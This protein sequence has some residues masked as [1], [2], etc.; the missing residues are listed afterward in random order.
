MHAKAP[1]P[2]L[3]GC[4]IAL[5]ASSDDPYSPA[6]YLAE[7]EANVL[8]FPVT[9]T[10]PPDSYDLLDQALQQAAQ[11][12]VD[13]LLL[14]TPCAVE[15]VA[16]RLQHLGISPK[17]FAKLK[18]SCFGAKTAHVAAALLPKLKHSVMES[19]SHKSLIDA[20]R[21]RK[22][23]HV[24]IPLA[25]RSR[26]DWP[27]LVSAT[28]AEPVGVPAYRLILGRGGDDLPGLLWGGLVDAVVF[29][30]ENSVR[31]FSVRLKAEGGALDM[32]HDVV[33]ACLDAQTAA[34]ANAFGLHVQVLPD[35][36]TYQTLAENLAKHFTTVPVTA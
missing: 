21:L 19:A 7:R 17:E 8:Y 1:A 24:L 26:A 20:M 25:Q 34:A 27:D 29:L 30:T 6:R 28:K 4:R 5:T 15:A 33:V 31:H 10:L 32:L 2:S 12:E 22:G 35:P 3:Q 36:P 14:P 23:K 9:Q 18:T 11:K 13:W 16:E